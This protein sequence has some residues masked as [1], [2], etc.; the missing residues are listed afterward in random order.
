MRTL[1]PRPHR[2]QHRTVRPVV[3]DLDDELGV[4]TADL[5]ALYDA[6][7]QASYELTSQADHGEHGVSREAED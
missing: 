4:S 5:D 6:A 2:R 3:I 7:D 1:S